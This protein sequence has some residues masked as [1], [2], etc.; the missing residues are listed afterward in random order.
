MSRVRTD[1]PARARPAP[2]RTD[3]AHARPAAEA[4][5]LVLHLSRLRTLLRRRALWLRQLWRNR[6][7][8]GGAL[9][10]AMIDVL[11]DADGGAAERRFHS[12]DAVALA[13]GRRAQ[14]LARQADALQQPQ[15]QS[16]LGLIVQRF[17]LAAGERDVLLLAAAPELD[18]AFA[19]LLAYCQ[20]DATRT[21]PSA[22]FAATLFAADAH[23]EAALRRALGA[24]GVLRGAQLIEQDLGGGL[25][26]AA[27]VL[28]LLNGASVSADVEGLTQVARQPLLTGAQAALALQ[29]GQWLQAQATPRQLNLVGPRGAGR[30]H[31]ARAA[32]GHAGLA[33]LRANPVGSRASLPP[34]TVVWREAVLAGAAVLVETDGSDEALAWLRALA[35]R[36]ALVVVSDAP[37]PAMHADLTLPVARPDRTAQH[38]LWQQALATWDLAADADLPA[39]VQQ[40]DLGPAAIAAAAHAASELARLREPRRPP[41][42]SSQDLRSACRA[43]AR[44][45]LDELAQRI[46]PAAGWD[47]LVLD[48]DTLAQMRALAAQVGSRARVYDDW[49]FGAALSRGRGICALFAGPSGTGKTMAA[50]VLAR[51]LDLELYRVD[52]AATLS[53][54]IGDTPKNLGRIFEAAERSG[55]LLFFDEADA[56]FARRTD[57][58]ESHDRYANVEVNYLLQRMES[59]TGITVLA[60]NRKNDFDRAFLR[61]LRFVIDFPFPDAAAR[62]RLWGKVF[63]AGARLE[64]LDLDTLARLELPGASIRTIALNA[65]FTAAHA[66]R[67]I[68][69]ADLLQAARREFTKLDRLPATALPI[70]AARAVEPTS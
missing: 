69:M 33:V 1:R 67:A 38:A 18:P 70:V 26:V 9:D 42:I 4:D 13:L 48:A 46:E 24:Q 44:A 58:R 19:T 61:R 21:R 60:S 30:S 51:A 55:A 57:V 52:L 39:V 28:D 15:E 49:G 16:P 2:S 37:L 53:K 47:D 54:Y 12:E 7:A 8:A 50:E 17:G 45:A 41:S 20:D 3:G 63:P 62:R 64:P 32:C 29:L 36:V 43:Q 59:Y 40:F 31:V 66:G 14:Q 25:V 34:A 6:P 11:F 65:A 27:R 56:L 22:A 68:G 23:G 10:D 35:G 5:A